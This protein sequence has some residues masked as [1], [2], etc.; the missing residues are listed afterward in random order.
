M[1]KLHKLI[2]ATYLGPFVLTF[3]ITLFILVMQFLWKYIDEMVGKGLESHIIAE[4]LFYA[5]ANLVPMA[6]PLA[7]LLSSI[8]TFGNLGEH[9]ELVSLKTAGMSLLK[10]MYPLMVVTILTSASAFYFSNNIWPIANLKFAT[11]LYDIR[12]TKPAFDIKKNVFYKGIDGYVIR[13]GDKDK[14]GQTIYDILIYDHTQRRGNNKV[15][16]AEKGIMQMSKD[17]KYLILT[18]YNGNSYEEM[19]SE[20]G[21]RYNYPLFRSEFD[22]EI[23][24]FNLSGFQ[25]ERTN[26]DL[27]KDNYQM[28]N[29]FQ[30][31]AAI[32]TLQL[33]FEKRK[34]NFTDQLSQRM[35]LFRDSSNVPASIPD[36]LHNTPFI[37]HFNTID[38]ISI[39]DN[40]VNLTRTSKT[41]VSGLKNQVESNQRSVWRHLIEWHRKLTLSFACIVLFFIGAPLGAIIRKGGL[42][43]P[44]VV[45]VMFFLVFHVLSITGEKLVKQGELL[46]WQGM[47]LA[48][49]FLFPIGVFL[50]YKAATDSVILDID[51]YRKPFVFIGNLFKRN[52]KS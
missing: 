42:G 49:A 47:W 31:Q 17:D 7:I 2:I 43:L 36:S 29:M 25:I 41:Y 15:I 22:E 14:D 48:T 45:S 11:L 26:E 44:V 37:A 40:A 35:L 19:Q 9:Y 16:T 21:R 38:K 33:H 51:T 39:L 3:F 50:T 12:Q 1:K 24:R 10:I 18:L 13:V 52:N 28:L 46:P 6:L 5:S 34:K 32:D 8:M 20:E 27:F 30:L 23:I 4:L